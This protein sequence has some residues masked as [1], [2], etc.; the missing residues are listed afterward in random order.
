MW[1]F[2]VLAVMVNIVIAVVNMVVC[3][4]DHDTHTLLPWV[5]G[6]LSWTSNFF[7]GLRR[8]GEGK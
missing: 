5:L 4:W 3:I 1:E 2:Y 6:A 8:M 7:W